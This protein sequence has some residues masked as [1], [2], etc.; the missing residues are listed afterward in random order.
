MNDMTDSES[1]GEPGQFRSMSERKLAE[2]LTH[3]LPAPLVWA[4][5]PDAMRVVATEGGESFRY[6]PDFLIRNEETGRVLAVELKTPQ[7]LSRSNLIK[8]KMISDAYHKAGEEFLLIVDGGQ[9]VSAVRTLSHDKVRTA[10]LGDA[11]EAPAISAIR[12]AL[13][14]GI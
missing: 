2:T 9:D 7:G 1:A 12:D 10:W 14:A 3:A 6:R 5:E 8:F 13:M 11:N 4:H